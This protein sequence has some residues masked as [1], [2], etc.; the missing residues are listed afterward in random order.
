MEPFGREG[1]ISNINAVAG[2]KNLYK[3]IS[4]F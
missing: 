4:A 3:A 1:G 2:I